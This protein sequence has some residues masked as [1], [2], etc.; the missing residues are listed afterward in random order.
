MST[1]YLA[2][3]SPQLEATL[4]GAVKQVIQEQAA[5]PVP[6]V[7]ALLLQGSDK[8]PAAAM[9]YDAFDPSRHHEPYLTYYGIDGA[10][11]AIKVRRFTRGEFWALGCRAAA[12]LQEH[13]LTKGDCATHYFTD[14]RV[15]DLAFRLGSV[16]LGT[17]PVT[18]NW[19]ADT[20]D[21]IVYKVTVTNSKAMVVDPDVPAEQ[22]Q[23]CKDAVGAGAPL[24][25]IVAADQLAAAWP[26]PAS[27][28]CSGLAPSDP[29]II[30]FT[31]GTTGKP[32]G[33]SLP[34]R[35][36]DTNR[37]TFEQ[38]LLVPP[39]SAPDAPAA[40][41]T[42]VVTNPMHHTNSTAIT[43][44][45]LRRR[46]APPRL[47]P[48]PPHRV[49]VRR[50]PPA[51]RRRRD[52][53]LHPH[54]HHRHLR[55]LLPRRPGASL[56]LLQRYTTQYWQIIACAAAGQRF[57]PDAAAA[58]A[59]AQDAAARAAA[60]C[61]VICPLVSR[62][63]DFLDELCKAGKLPADG[64]AFRTA[65]CAA[66]PCAAPLDAGAPTPVATRSDEGQG[67]RGRGLAP[68]ALKPGLPRLTCRPLPPSACSPRS[69]GTP[70]VTLLLGSAPVGP[71][72]VER[73]TTHCGLLP[74]VRFG[75]T[76]TC[77]QVMGTPLPRGTTG[78]ALTPFERGWAHEWKGVPSKGYYIGRPHP[79]NTEVMVVR[80]VVPGGAGYLDE[81]ADG[82]P[83]QLVC[84]GGFLMSGYVGDAAATKKAIHTEAGGWYVNLGDVCFA[85]PAADGAKDYYWLSRDSAL[86]IRG[87]AN[88]AYE[89]I[90]V[91]LTKWAQAHFGSEEVEVAVVGLKLES[92]HEDTCC[93]TVELRGEAA[94][95]APPPEETEAAA[96][97][98]LAAAKKAVAAGTVSKGS[99][100]DRA[101]FAP[102][103][104]NFK[105]A[106][107]IPD[108][109]QAW[110]QATGKA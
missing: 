12:L 48:H 60:G 103:P 71:M 89:Q 86:L 70:L 83:G 36:Y 65:C 85:L 55:R 18:I 101:M 80:S 91:E 67:G 34:Y 96:A 69:S 90:N 24:G 10:T 107:L 104:K 32:K 2:K 81:C 56:H 73:L 31:S 88:Y 102:I 52:R 41:F 49:S 14:N 22:I 51:A 99:K 47:R 98:F 26:L 33:V 76:E 13:G 25:I 61:R 3:H 5:D 84:R 63:I 95:L 6:R 4:T 1:K 82:E 94:K 23:M 50:A 57:P 54:R 58:S 45:T 11:K 21:R 42:A 77:L 109:L 44:W 78:A 29:R 110:K 43:D 87:G 72:T 108:L 79:G 105:G 15:E 16:L 30:I 35:A 17:V 66:S 40:D 8:S 75:S 97:A 53:R 27:G 38:F 59:L 46:A 20:P 106:V 68:I 9:G 64:A 39:A 92:E 7:A 74:T 37:A 19:Q 62:H 93:A 100:P 28:F